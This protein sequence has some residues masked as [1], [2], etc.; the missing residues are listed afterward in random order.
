MLGKVYE[1]HGRY[2][3]VLQWFERVLAGR[4][5]ELRAD[6]SDTLSTVII[7]HS[8]SATNDSMR[9]RWRS[10]NGY[11]LGRGRRWVLTIHRRKTQCMA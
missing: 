2:G 3:M 11:W 7:W 5:K 8:Y 10:M 9:R 1:Y 6:H 4:E